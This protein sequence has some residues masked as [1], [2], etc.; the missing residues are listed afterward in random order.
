MSS[1]VSQ[2]IKVQVTAL[3]GGPPVYEFALN[4]AG[5]EPHWAPDSKAI[6]YS[7]DQNGVSNIWEQRLTGGPPRQITHFKSAHIF[8]FDWSPD[9]RRLALTRGSVG[10]DVVLIRDFR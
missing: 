8:D 1:D 6:Q 9:G 5:G 3:E 2:S 4:P 10:R 7:L